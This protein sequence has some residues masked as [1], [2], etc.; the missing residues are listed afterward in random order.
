V[1]GE[2]W[3]K[4]H[5]GARYWNRPEDTAKVFT[6]GWLHTGTWRVSR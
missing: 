5:S 1:T 6:R 2:P 3:I 4:G